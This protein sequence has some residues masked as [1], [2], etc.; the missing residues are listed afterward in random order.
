MRVEEKISYLQNTFLFFLL[1]GPLLFWKLITF[2]LLLHLKLFKML[3]ECQLKCTNN[4]GIVIIIEQRTKNFLGVQ[5]LVVVSCFE[6]LTPPPL[7]LGAHNF[8][9]FSQFLMIFSA[10]DVPRRGVQHWLSCYQQKSP[11]LG[12]RLP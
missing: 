2:S 6:S 9:I 3:Q 4:L 5:K 7:T 11:P 8:F 12:S 1:F 10:L